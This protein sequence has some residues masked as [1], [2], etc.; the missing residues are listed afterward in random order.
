MTP[1][2]KKNLT[3]VQ[4]LGERLRIVREDAGYTLKAAA[5]KTGIQ[6]K[7]LRALEQSDYSQ[8]PSEIYTRSFLKRYAHWL[9]LNPTSVLR[10]Y[11]KER[12]VLEKSNRSLGQLHHTRLGLPKRNFII[13]YKIIK[14]SFIILVILAIFGYLGFIMYNSAA[15]PELQVFE[16][17]DNIII[18]EY[19]IEVTGQVESESKLEING[20]EIFSDADGNFRESVNLQEGVNIIEIEA[21]KRRGRSTTIYRKVLV[22]RTEK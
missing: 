17:D 16:P 18:S 22:Q 4:T 1:F 8:L 12:T 9:E 20:Q 21:Y 5:E 7:Y 6:E 15:P 2:A 10:A 3:N 14:R 11:E 13:T 19:N